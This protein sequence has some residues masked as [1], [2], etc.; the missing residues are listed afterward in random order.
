MED[1]EDKHEAWT[2]L[3]EQTSREQDPA[4]LI[5]LTHEIVRLLEQRRGQLNEP[6][7]RRS[8]K[9]LNEINPLLV[10]EDARL[11]RPPPRP[12]AHDHNQGSV[13]CRTDK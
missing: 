12:E 8:L 11:R 10:E 2:K 6:P 4:K 13:R 5:R 7:P 1:N 9:L 3:C